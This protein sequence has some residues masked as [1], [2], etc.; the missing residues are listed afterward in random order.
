MLAKICWEPKPVRWG[1]A[2][3]WG[4]RIALGENHAV[5]QSGR[6][7]GSCA[8]PAHHCAC[9]GGAQ[10]NL[11]CDCIVVIRDGEKLCSAS[12]AGGMCT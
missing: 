11:R 2:P 4:P 7:S 9:A 6:S 5:I 10:R 3:C 12:A 8:W 1:A